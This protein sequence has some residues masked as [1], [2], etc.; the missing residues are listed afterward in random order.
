MI[1]VVVTTTSA[2]NVEQN[3]EHAI[4]DMCSQLGGVPHGTGAASSDLDKNQILRELMPVFA[5][6]SDLGWTDF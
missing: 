1:V 2:T 5:S 4:A 3:M 6:K